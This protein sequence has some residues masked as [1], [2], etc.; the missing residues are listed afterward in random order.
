MSDIPVIFLHGWQG[1]QSTYGKIPGFLKRD[2]FDVKDIFLGKYSSGDDRIGIEDYAVAFQ[3]AVQDRITQPFDVIIHSTGA[4]IVRTWFLKFYKRKDP[5]PVRNFIMMAPA[6]NGSRLAGWAHKW[7]GDW[8]NKLLEALTLGAAF[9]WNLNWKYLE[10]GYATLPGLKN[11]VIMG[12]KNDQVLPWYLKAIDA[13]DDGFGIN[14]P[15]FEEEGSDGVVR[16]AAANPNMKG[17]R[18]LPGQNIAGAKISK[19]NSIPVYTFSERGHT[20]DERGILMGEKKTDPVY[21]LILDILREQKPAQA[22]DDLKKHPFVMINIRVLDQLGNPFEDFIPLFYQKPKE[23]GLIEFMHRH[24]NHE[25]D[26]HFIKIPDI[27]KVTRFG[28]K[29]PPRDI[30]NMSYAASQEIDLYWPEKKVRFLEPGKTHFIEIQLEKT[31]SS[32]AFQF[33]HPK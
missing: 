30:G 31:I 18:L 25:I 33:T 16:I 27:S 3:D 20:G 19:I 21:K 10:A 6:T 2:G 32:K 12:T 17:V 13:I 5:S 11:H 29:I 26:C 23:A 7:P 15:A 8:G 1:D 28:F 22:P 4:L 14:I 9:T 24:E